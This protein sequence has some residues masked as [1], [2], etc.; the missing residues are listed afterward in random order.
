MD[1]LPVFKGL[2]GPL[3]IR[4]R[5]EARPDSEFFLGFHTWDPSIT[6]L[7]GTYYC[8]NGKAY[9]GN[10]PTLEAQVGQRVAF[11][12]YGVDNFFHTFHLHGHRWTEPRRARSST[13]KPS[14]RPTRSGSSSSRTT[15]AAG[16]TTA[17]SSSTCTRG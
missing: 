3:V 17:T 15:R 10:T 13:T 12:V 5:G 14:A 1:P 7:K 11:H 8:V 6:G 16:S 2:F 4:A 9:A